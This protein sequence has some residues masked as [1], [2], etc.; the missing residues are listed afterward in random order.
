MKVIEPQKKKK[1]EGKKFH[2]IVSPKAKRHTHTQ[3]ISKS[4][5]FSASLEAINDLVK[6]SK[7]YTL[8]MNGVMANKKNL[9]Q[10][11]CAVTKKLNGRELRNSNMSS[12]IYLIT[13]IAAYIDSFIE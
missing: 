3:L 13:K 7:T 6:L 2:I 12:R 5:Q 1:S 10:P 9:N 11:R 8:M 4:C